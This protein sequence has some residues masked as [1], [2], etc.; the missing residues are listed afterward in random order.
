MPERII[1]LARS[2]SDLAQRSVSDIQRVTDMTKVLSLNALIEATRAGAAGAGFAVVAKEVRQVSG[3]ISGIATDLREK[4]TSRAGELDAAG[5]SLIGDIRGGRLSDLAFNMI[6]IIDRN[7][8]ERSCDVRWWATDSAVVDAATQRS[9]ATTRHAGGR[10]GVIL[11]SYTVYL[12]LWVCDLQGN[13]LASGRPEQYKTDRVNVAHESWFKQAMA[14]RDGSE[15]SVS[16]IYACP[17]LGDRYVAAYGAA[18]RAGGHSTGEPVGVLGIFFDWQAQSQAVFSSVRLS[19]EERGTTR[20]MIVDSRHRVIAASDG[21][22]VLTE[23]IRLGGAR[24][25]AGSFIDGSE[26]IVGY[27]LTPGYESY[28][29]LG[30]YGVLRQG[31]EAGRAGKAA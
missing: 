23:T 5:K 30:W 29:G 19:T 22:G 1:K 31:I 12:D 25:T 4:L 15:F 21:K 27:A 26:A 8:Y 14:S 18:V 16:D 9:E 28:R 13:V 24:D 3:Q 10:L 20:C 6:E 2:M 7:L 17:A 11:G